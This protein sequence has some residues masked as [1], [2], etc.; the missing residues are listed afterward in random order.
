M[1][2][3]DLL[4]ID[5]F[6]PAIKKEGSYAINIF[7]QMSYFNVHFCMFEKRQT[8]DFGNLGGAFLFYYILLFKRNICF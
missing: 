8:G 1:C 3:L 4:Q 5:I 7:L 6:C 2:V